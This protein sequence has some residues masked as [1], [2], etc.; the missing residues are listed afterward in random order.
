MKTI[1]VVKGWLILFI[2]M[3]IKNQMKVSNLTVFLII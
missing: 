3:Q 2:R 1:G